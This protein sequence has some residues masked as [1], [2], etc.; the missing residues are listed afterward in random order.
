MADLRDLG[1]RDPR[2]ALAAA[3]RLL[4]ARGL[5]AAWAGNGSVRT[6]HGFLATPTGMCLGLVEPEVLVALDPEGRAAGPGRP[7]SEWPLHRALYRARSGVVAVLHTHSP[8]A[9]C[10]AVRERGIGP[11]TPEIAH[12][13]GEVPCVAF[14]PPGTE[15]LGEAVAAAARRDRGGALLARHGAV[16][17]GRSVA[18]AF[19]LAELVEEAAALA[20]RA[21]VGVP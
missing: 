10:L 14:A 11:L 20:V 5:V 7:T 3:C 2:V 18:E 16:A 17:W 8:F 9:T 13:L 15:A 4:W 1:D 6:D 12:H 21:G 19:F